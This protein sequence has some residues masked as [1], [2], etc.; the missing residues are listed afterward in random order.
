MSDNEITT[1]LLDIKAKIESCHAQENRSP[2]LVTATLRDK[3]RSLAAAFVDPEWEEGEHPP[4]RDG[5]AMSQD[6]DPR[7]GF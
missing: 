5:K 7:C 1:A 6:I 2:W 4:L 3:A